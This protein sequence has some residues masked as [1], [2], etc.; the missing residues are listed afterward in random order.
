MKRKYIMGETFQEAILKN[1]SNDQELSERD[2]LNWI[3]SI[4]IIENPLSLSSSDLEIRLFTYKHSLN[5]KQIR[6]LTKTENQCLNFISR[7]YKPYELKNIDNILAIEFTQYDM[8]VFYNKIRIN[9]TKF[10]P[11]NKMKY[12]KPKT[13]INPNILKNKR[14]W[15][16]I[17]LEDIDDYIL[18][19][20]M[21]NI[22]ISN[23]EVSSTQEILTKL[24]KLYF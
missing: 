5:V 12:Q 7:L 10:K 8:E 22:D 2:K 23:I 6:E 18:R 17:L 14:V 1:I 19:R 21:K 9:N 20:S 11:G 3:D 15:R 24:S 13:Y 4:P 16:V